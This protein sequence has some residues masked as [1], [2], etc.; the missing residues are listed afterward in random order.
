MVPNFVTEVDR[1]LYH[2]K[3]GKHRLNSERVTPAQ[4]LKIRHHSIH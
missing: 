3:F 1:T 2:T 4:S